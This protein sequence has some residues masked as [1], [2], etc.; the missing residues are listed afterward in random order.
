[1][2]KHGTKTLCENCGESDTTNCRWELQSKHMREVQGRIGEMVR[3]QKERKK[4]RKKGEKR[5]RKK[6]E[7]RGKKEKKREKKRGKKETMRMTITNA[8]GFMDA[9]KNIIGNIEGTLRKI[10][11]D[12]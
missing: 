5:E 2:G 12:M 11:I 9:I 10:I 1:M 7:K 4:E 6:R 8:H 3:E